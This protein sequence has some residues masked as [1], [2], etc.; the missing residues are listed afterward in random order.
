VCLF[1]ALDRESGSSDSRSTIGRDVG[2]GQ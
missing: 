1:V 2:A